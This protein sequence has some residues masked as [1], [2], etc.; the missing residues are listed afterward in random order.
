MQGASSWDSLIISEVSKTAIV[1]PV[2]TDAN[3]VV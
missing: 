1:S 3:F 2:N